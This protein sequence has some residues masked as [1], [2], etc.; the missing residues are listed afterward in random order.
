LIFFSRAFWRPNPARTATHPQRDHKE[1]KKKRKEERKER[2]NVLPTNPNSDIKIYNISSS[3]SLPEWLKEN[4][5]KSLKKD[6]GM[7]FF[8]YSFIF[9]SIAFPHLLLCLTH[10]LS[11]CA[12]YR[13]RIELLQD[14]E[15][16]T[17]SQRIKISRDGQYLA[18]TGFFCCCIVVSLC[19][20]STSTRTNRNLSSCYQNV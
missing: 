17:A 19:G 18:A 11:L 4:K 20:F 16:S 5:K 7:V 10:S 1:K 13:K 9:P 14:F 2:M 15:F 3:K 8:T 12:D 6:V